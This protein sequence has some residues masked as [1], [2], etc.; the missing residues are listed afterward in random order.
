MKPRSLIRRL[1]FAFGTLS[2]LLF[3]GAWYLTLKWRPALERQLKELVLVSSDSLYSVSYASLNINLLA[4]N[5][6]IRDFKLKADPR[7][8]ENLLK[9][10][11]APENLFEL[12]VN[13]VFIKRFHPHH[14]YTNRELEIR[15]MLF[16]QPELIMTN[17]P[18]LEK[19]SLPELPVYKQLQPILNRLHIERIALRNS[20]F[21]F[22]Q[23]RNQYIRNIRFNN[24]N[25]D[26]SD[27]LVDSIAA[28]DTSRFY[29]TRN[30]E[31]MLNNYRYTTPDSM[32][33]LRIG[34]LKLSA[35]DKRLIADQISL[36]PTL[37]LADFYKK[38]GF[39]KDRFNINVNQLAFDQLD[40]EALLRKQ[41]LFGK[42]V[43]INKPEVVVFNNNV[44][45]KKL[46]K[47]VLFPQQQ[48]KKLPFQLKLDTINIR[49]GTFIYSEFDRDSRKTGK[50]V[51]SHTGGKILNVTNQ[52]EAL[53][54]NHIA[55][56][57]LS[58]MLYNKGRLNTTFSFDL[59]SPTGA[60]D[61]NGSLGEMNGRVLNEITKPLGLLEINNGKVN[62]LLFNVK[63]DQELAKGS[64]SFFYKDLSVQLFER[65][66][67]T[68]TLRK[69]GIMSGIANVFVLEPSNP[70]ANGDFITADINYLRP[71]DVSFFSYIWK[72]LFIGIKQSVGIS[73][74]KEQRLN[75]RLT[76]IAEFIAELKER[77]AVRKKQL[78]S[79][80][81]QRKKQRAERLKKRQKR[82]DKKGYKLKKPS[83]EGLNNNS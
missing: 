13:K 3:A 72:T 38:A 18:Q 1:L 9:L 54:Q 77:N 27:L 37:N 63:A 5:A 2:I 44:Y 56:A 16:E 24:A 31:L 25:I 35:V 50:I 65:N 76:K 32:Y 47:N 41:R 64:M 62:K 81:A 34:K 48:L 61:F 39:A 20:R 70:D 40:M 51:F 19:D 15:S 46:R 67:S 73:K 17:V 7:I 14:L 58:S 69:Q 80:K 82:Q 10:K 74:E 68:G 42:I 33:K 21:I 71:S 28:A 79:I 8:Y 22:R 83:E 60:F 23:K 53:K 36:T 52:L 75:K 11:K 43:D 6:E 49:Y 12:Q 59:N 78:E 4:G 45:P 66:E 57:T 29:Y 30:V 26:I 55:K